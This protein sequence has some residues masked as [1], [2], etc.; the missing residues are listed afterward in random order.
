VKTYLAANHLPLVSVKAIGVNGFGRGINDPGVELEAVL[1]IDMVIGINPAVKEVLVYEDGDDPF[2]VALVDS[3]TAMATD[4]TAQTISIS[5]G[6]DERLQDPATMQSENTL[7]TQL[8]PQGQSVFASAGD[9]GAYGRSGR[10][11]NVEDPGSQPLL[12]SV[13]GTTL[14]TDNSEQYVAEM[15]WGEFGVGG[16]AMGGGVS[17]VWT[18]PDDQVV[19]GKSV[20]LPNGG[21]ATNRNVPD[22]AAVADPFTGVSVYSYLNGG[23]LMIAGTSASAPIWAGFMS[24]ANHASKAAGFGQIGFANPNLYKF[25]NYGVFTDVVD[26]ENGDKSLFGKAGFLAGIGYDNTTGMGSFGWYLD[27]AMALASVD[28]NGNGPPA[29]RGLSAKATAT[30]IDASWT[31][32]TGVDGYIVEVYSLVTQQMV[33]SQ[34]TAGT[35]VTVK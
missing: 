19:N 27:N 6:T 7:L 22:V 28:P 10:G 15:A 1:D 21:S 25:A 13:G 33:F 34:I 23:W 30:T 29:P 16:G 24:I 9:N 26:G 8:A 11:R 35:N 18:I 4:N 17:T 20:G 31:A 2:G 5:Y 12:T 3:L 14:F 32:G